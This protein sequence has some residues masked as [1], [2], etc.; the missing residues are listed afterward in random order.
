MPCGCDEVQARMHS[1]VWNLGIEIWAYF[2]Y[3]IF[4]RPLPWWPWSRPQGSHRT[5]PRCTQE[6]AP[7]SWCCRP[8]PRT[9]GCR[10]QSRPASLRSP[11]AHSGVSPPRWSVRAILRWPSMMLD[12]IVIHLKCLSVI[13]LLL[14]LFCP[15]NIS[16]EHWVHLIMEGVI[17]MNRKQQELLIPRWICQAPTRRPPSDWTRNPS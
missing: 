9:R 6:S 13:L 11:P 14:A 17:D 7:S 8:R 4:C 1:S 10:S 12:L 5:G 15:V 3:F 2:F 16:Q